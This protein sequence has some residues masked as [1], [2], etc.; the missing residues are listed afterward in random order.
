MESRVQEKCYLFGFDFVS[1]N[2]P[3]SIFLENNKQ[4]QEKENGQRKISNWS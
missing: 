2:F 1:C 4:I 3:L